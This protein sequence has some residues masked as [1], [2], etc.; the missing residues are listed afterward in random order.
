MMLSCGIKKFYMRI[1]DHAPLLQMD[2]IRD[3]KCKIFVITWIYTLHIFRRKVQF[4]GL[5]KSTH[6]VCLKIIV[7]KIG[8]QKNNAC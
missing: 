6:K 1:L 4:Y 8:K 2:L 3:G 5:S 7:D